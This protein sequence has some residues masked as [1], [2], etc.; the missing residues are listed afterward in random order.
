[1]SDCK[2]GLY[3][4]YVNIL[5]PWLCIARYVGAYLF[6]TSFVVIVVLKSIAHMAYRVFGWSMLYTM[7]R[8]YMTVSVDIPYKS[9]DLT[10]ARPSLWMVCG[11]QSY[12]QGLYSCSA[13][14]DYVEVAESWCNLFVRSTR[15][16]RTL[17][18]Q[19]AMCEPTVKGRSAC[20]CNNNNSGVRA[21]HVTDVDF[22]MAVT[23]SVGEYAVVHFISMCMLCIM[24]F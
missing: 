19:T 13:F 4:G 2:L 14:V 1:M 10:P 11:M 21:H 5:C 17:R 3:F 9:T 12:L 8:M 7:H 16:R 22:W 24:M 23:D 6:S 15:T 20:V 18:D